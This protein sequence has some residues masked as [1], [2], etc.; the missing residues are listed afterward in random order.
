MRAIS[1][2]FLL[3]IGFNQTFSQTATSDGDWQNNA[4]WNAAYP[5]NG[6]DGDGTL[7]LNGETLN[8]DSYITLGSAANDVNVHVANSNFAGEFIVNDTLVIFGDV[9]FENKS[10]ELTVTSNGVLIVFGNLSMNNKI[11]VSSDGLIVVTEAFD[12]SGSTG[13]NDY[14]GAG[15]V[16][17]GSYTGNA[18]SEIDNSGDGNGDSS[19]LIDDLSVDGFETIEEFVGGGGATPLPVELLYFDV[20]VEKDI[21][22]SWAT[23]SE[24]NN[25]YFIIERSEDGVYFYEIGRVKGNG[26]TNQKIE[27]TFTDRFVLA[28]TEYY[29]LKQIDFDGAFEYFNIE[30]VNTGLEN[31]SNSITAYPTTVD[32]DILSISSSKPLKIRDIIFFDLSGGLNRNLKQASSKVNELSYKINLKELDNGVYLL[33]LVSTEGDEFS[34][35]IIVK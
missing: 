19:F 3:I 6:T 25:D 4:N 29:R 11:S 28:P 2:V 30:I 32:N 20:Q 17:A 8:I 13:N 12:M 1:I 9:F 22:L 14:S 15:N 10:M 23:A 34:S 31:E 24:V 27:Y 5:G 21:K 7:N 18:E 16:Y 33:R 35:R 26:N